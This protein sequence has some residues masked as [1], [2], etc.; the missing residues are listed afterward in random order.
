MAHPLAENGLPPIHHHPHAPMTGNRKKQ[1]RRAKQQAK[2]N[3]GSDEAFSDHHSQPGRPPSLPE[4]LT[5]DEDD[6]DDLQATYSARPPLGN[7]MN[8]Y[9]SNDDSVEPF[10][11]KRNKKK[12]RRNSNHSVYADHMRPPMHHAP[13]PHSM[14]MSTGAMRSGQHTSRQDRIWNT[15]T[16]EERERIKQFWLTLSEDERKSLLKIE[17]EA[18]LR[19]MKEQQK[20][21]CSC[22]VCGRKRIAIEE[23][24][25]VLYDAYYDELEQYAHHQGGEP[26]HGMLPPPHSLPPRHLH[27][28]S[29][30]PLPLS[31][32][33]QHPH[34]RP[35]RVREVSE[36]EDDDQEEEEDDI[37]DQELSEEEGEEEEYSDEEY[38]DE[39][40]ELEDDVPRGIG[41]DF[42]NF[43]NSLTVKGMFALPLMRDRNRTEVTLGGILTVADDLLKNDGKKFIEMME[44]LAERR[45]QREQQAEYDSAQPSHTYTSNGHDPP[46]DDEEYD[47]EDYDE[48]EYDEDSQDEEDEDEMVTRDNSWEVVTCVTDKVQGGMTEEQRMEEGRRMFQIF[49][50]RMF[51][52][53][54]L[55]AYR[56]KVAAERQQKLLEEL[57]DENK[58]Q[59]EREAKKARD[60]EKKKNKKQAQKQAKAEEKARKDAEKA[61]EEAAA[62]AIEQAKQEE[63]KQRREAQRRKKEADRR[64]QEEERQRKEVERLKRQQE[65][66]ERQQEAERKLREQK[67]LEKKQ[68]EEARQKER[69]EREARE[70]EAKEKKAQAE[71]EKRE[72]EMKAKADK[73]A[74]SQ[75]ASQ[76]IKRSSQAGMV[77]VPP[78]LLTK[79][80]SSILSSPH[81][82]VATP[83]L[84]KPSTPAQP[85]QSSFQGQNATSP[86]S[87]QA[88]TLIPTKSTSPGHAFNQSMPK[89][90]LQKSQNQQ[91]FSQHQPIS[92]ASQLPLPG[93]YSQHQNN[94]FSGFP[95]SMAGFPGFG[96][97]HGP[98]MHHRPSL[99]GFSNGPF[100]SGPFQPMPPINSMHTPPPG[101]SG[102]GMMAQGR[103][104]P[105]ESPQG[106]QQQMPAVGSPT[107]PPGFGLT[108]HSIASHSRTHSSDKN[109]F[110]SISSPAPITRPTPIQ[111]PSSIRP[112]NPD[113]DGLSKHLGSSAL[114]DDTDDPLPSVPESRRA[115]AITGPRGFG[116]PVFTQTQPR[117]DVFGANSSW[118]SPSLFGAPPGFST[119]SSSWNPN[120]SSGW[121][122][123]PFGNLGHRPSGPN[124]PQSIRIAVCHACKQLA[125]REPTP[126]DYHSVET[127]LRQIETSR[128]VLDSPIMVKEI[129]AICD[130]EGDA[131]NGGG[132][133][134]ARQDASTP[135]GFAVKFEPDAGTPGSGRHSHP[136]GPISSPVPGHSVPATGFGGPTAIGRGTSFQSL[137]SAMA[138]SGSS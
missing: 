138:T 128:P 29:A 76:M 43:G 56:E 90:I 38:S 102:L 10:R 82:A 105:L 136:L 4:A 134:H 92:P 63:A 41:N 36:Y 71:R 80:T 19:K 74:R 96:A 114:L 101:M 64:A 85:R 32:H 66:R 52:Q 121:S 83:A 86:R 135:G 61:A 97:P 84:P 21:S 25:E 106:F 55:T 65:E 14:P 59:Q 44:Q 37:D 28:S 77:A 57:D 126:D 119:P 109:T 30:V 98:M 22:T 34:H 60:A 137:G 81:V 58:Q 112:N 122:S 45:M 54:V 51:E 113:M 7:S 12:K 31:T 20:H 23:E 33:H 49:A 120:S 70:K 116:S 75:Q 110:E 9:P 87:Q 100:G 39:E 27:P 78:G 40:E 117:M 125:T 50:A 68:K 118:T 72:R 99:P 48:E 89:S 94:G 93:M 91:P 35:N 95:T 130:T 15:S 6:E 88:P 5:D 53:R 73:E 11:K 79:Q 108:R 132:F 2:L 3:P 69:E 133:L 129:E 127:L 111:R 16:Q 42:F 24:L 104:Y 18:V 115:S 67:A 13:L 124:R 46:L 131:Q 47:D 26:G 62:K 17:K 107:A 8:S 1:K 123:I 103:G